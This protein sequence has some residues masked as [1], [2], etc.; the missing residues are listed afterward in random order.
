MLCWLLLHNVNQ[1]CVHT[2]PSLLNLSSI[3]LVPPLEIVTEHWTI[4]LTQPFLNVAARSLLL[5]L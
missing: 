4:Y 5:K 1:L 3:P 2:D